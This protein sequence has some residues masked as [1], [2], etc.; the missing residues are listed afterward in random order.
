MSAYAPFSETVRVRFG[1]ILSLSGAL[2]HT[3]WLQISLS[4]SIK[5]WMPKL[6]F[7]YTDSES[8]LAMSHKEYADERSQEKGPCATCF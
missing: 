6:D 7:G 1:A 2:V 5:K 8:H 4:P 3:C